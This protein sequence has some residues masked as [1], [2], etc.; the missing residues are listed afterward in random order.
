[1]EAYDQAKHIF[2]YLWPETFLVNTSKR[3]VLPGKKLTICTVPVT[4]S[5]V[6]HAQARLGSSANLACAWNETVGYYKF[7]LS[8]A[9]VSCDGCRAEIYGE[10]MIAWFSWDL[11]CRALKLKK[12]IRRS[13]TLIQNIRFVSAKLKSTLLQTTNCRVTLNKDI[14]AGFFYVEIPFEANRSANK[15]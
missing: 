10:R 12:T 3:S 15:S 13:S 1:M 6:W 2:F 5:T 7:I 8:Y 11:G 9:N 14:A 4:P